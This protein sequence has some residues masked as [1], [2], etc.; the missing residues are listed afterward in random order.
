MTTMLGGL[1]KM[2]KN[3]FYFSFKGSKDQIGL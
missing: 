3:I 2:D 1:D